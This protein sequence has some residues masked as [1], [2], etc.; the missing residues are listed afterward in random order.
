MTGCGSLRA[1]SRQ[2][3]CARAR[4]QRLGARRSDTSRLRRARI[5]AGR[6]LAVCVRRERFPL[7]FHRCPVSV[8]GVASRHEKRPP[9]CSGGGLS[10]ATLANARSTPSC[11]RDVR[12]RRSRAP[13]HTRRRPSSGYAMPLRSMR[14]SISACGSLTPPRSTLDSIRRLMSSIVKFCICSVNAWR[15]WRARRFSRFSASAVFLAASAALS[16]QSRPSASRSRSARCRTG[17]RYRYRTYSPS[18]LVTSPALPFDATQKR[19]VPNA[20]RR[21]RSPAIARAVSAAC[22]ARCSKRIP[23]IGS[24]GGDLCYLKPRRCEPAVFM[25][26]PAC[27]MTI[28]SFSRSM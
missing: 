13:R 16:L 19:P 15:F 9:P 27:P 10:P 11:P 12:S 1:R 2:E 14:R 7:A 20:G 5:E 22:F 3:S 26:H 21:I 17:H 6:G 25:W 4:V 24:D 18:P 8:P 23:A 28:S